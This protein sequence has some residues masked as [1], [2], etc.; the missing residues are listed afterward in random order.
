M[1]TMVFACL[2]VRAVNSTPFCAL[3]KFRPT[4]DTEFAWAPFIV[5]IDMDG[6]YAP[7]IYRSCKA[8]FCCSIRNVAST[9]SVR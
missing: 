8:R 1:Q 2:F 7:D 9:L 3:L 4:I 6:E 5:D